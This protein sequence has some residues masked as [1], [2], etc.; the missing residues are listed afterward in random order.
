METDDKLAQSITV[1]KY[2]DDKDIYNRVRR[3]LLAIS[4][5]EHASLS[6][7]LLT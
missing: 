1:F 4:S 3:S 2:L 6:C 5:V 7:H